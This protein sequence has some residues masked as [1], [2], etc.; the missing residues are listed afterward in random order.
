MFRLKADFHSGK[1]KHGIG[2]DR[3]KI[4]PL[5]QFE[6]VIRNA[7]V[8]EFKYFQLFWSGSVDNTRQKKVR[9]DPMF[10]FLSEIGLQWFRYYI[11]MATSKY[12][13]VVIKQTA[14]CLYWEFETQD[15]TLREVRSHI[16]G[17]S[18]TSK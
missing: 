10:I 6:P 16:A 2:P 4:E 1:I 12:L 7:D 17:A 18:S 5:F 14:P 3:N 9:S 13:F 8:K 15:P 11:N